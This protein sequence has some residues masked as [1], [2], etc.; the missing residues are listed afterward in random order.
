MKPLEFVYLKSW[1]SGQVTETSQFK[2]WNDYY[3][4]GTATLKNKFTSPGNP[5]GQ[6]D[7]DLLEEAEQTATNIRI[8]QLAQSPIPGHFNYD[9]MKR[10]HRYIFQDVYEWAGQERVAPTNAHMT[11]S[12]ADVVHYPLGDPAAPQIT[13]FFY[14]AGQALTDA[15]N[16]Q[17]EKLAANNYLRGLPRERFITELAEIWG[18][19]NT[20]H[21]FREGNTRSQFVFFS[22]L[23][24]E[25]GWDINTIAYINDPRIM[26]E[27]KAARFYSQ[28]TGS[29][30]RIANVI[31]KHLTQIKN[32]GQ[33]ARPIIRAQSPQHRRTHRTYQVRPP[34]T[35]RRNSQQGYS[36]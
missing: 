34:I 15:A 29:N 33:P 11:K 30:H 19:I 20:I 26:N 32:T 18:E 13:Y 23:A 25:A 27:F 17:Y 9:H 2:T 36:L 3:I 4:P 35:P 5:Y 12:W 7:P 14:P 22:Q 28:A 16:A 31:A 24:S 1:A 8:A 6:T 21:S 10:I